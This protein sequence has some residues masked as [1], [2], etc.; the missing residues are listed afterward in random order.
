MSQPPFKPRPGQVDYT[1]IRYAPVINCVLR[2]KGKLF[3]VRRSDDLN[4]YPGYWNGISGFLDDD[5]SIVEKV[6]EELREELHMAKS[7]IKKIHVGQVFD[8]DAPKYKK[9]W[10]V[11][12][13][14]VDVTTDKVKLDWEA[15]RGEWLTF[16]QIRKLKLLPGFS[17]VLRSLRK[18][19]KV[20]A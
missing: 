10:I 16:A 2:Y 19:I 3:V 5:L 7:K 4:F 8:Q 12:P 11:H 18:W 9:T 17:D 20:A 14:L 6:T 15:R 1:Y 13:V